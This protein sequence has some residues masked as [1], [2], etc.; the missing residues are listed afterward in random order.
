MIVAKILGARVTM[1]GGT[2]R[3]RSEDVVAVLQVLSDL[4]Q[5]ARIGSIPD[6]DRDLVED[7]LLR[8]GGRIV[9]LREHEQPEAVAGR[10]Y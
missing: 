1:A 2:W 5:E 6:S 9:S 10:V 3:G 4:R 7:A 8:L